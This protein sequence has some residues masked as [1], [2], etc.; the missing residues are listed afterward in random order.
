MRDRKKSYDIKEEDIRSYF[1]G[2]ATQDQT[3]RVRRWMKSAEG[4]DYV[5]EMMDRDVAAMKDGGDPAAMPDKVPSMKMLREINHRLHQK[6]RYVLLGRI[7]AVLLPLLILNTVVFVQMT[8]GEREGAAEKV[9]S[10]AA[11]EQ[12]RVML[13]DGTNVTLNSGS[14][15]TYPSRFARRE[16]VVSVE[17]EAFFEVE[18]DAK[19]PFRVEAREVSIEVLGTK[20]NVNTVDNPG[21]TSVYLKEGSVRLTEKVTDKNAR[22][23]MRPGQLA[24]VSQS[25][26]KYYVDN[27]PNKASIEGWMHKRYYYK[28]APLAELVRHLERSYGAIFTIDDHKLYEYTY[29]MSFANES[30]DDIL[31][32]MESITP[33]RCVNSNNRVTI[34]AK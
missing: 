22:Y 7:A 31:R 23:Q 19:R 9:V 30:I 12:L 5:S 24:V 10:V 2:E 13:H 29:T 25:T 34:Y 4:Q 27:A 20:F 32:Q 8:R 28:D 33:I 18:K 26:G 1:D 21:A 16:R 6:H 11:G 17:G 15:L 3:I 14:T